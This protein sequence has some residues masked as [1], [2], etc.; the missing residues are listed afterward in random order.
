[1]AGI[2]SKKEQIIG[3]ALIIIGAPIWIPIWAIRKAYKKL[4]GRT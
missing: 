4:K 3:G 1:M 2:V